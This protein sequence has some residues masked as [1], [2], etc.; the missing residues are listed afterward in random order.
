MAIPSPTTGKS[1]IS[2]LLATTAVPNT[3]SD[4]TARPIFRPYSPTVGGTRTFPS[5][6]YILNNANVPPATPR[7]DF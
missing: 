7:A 5:L 2:A 1:M 6:Q 4:G 3:D